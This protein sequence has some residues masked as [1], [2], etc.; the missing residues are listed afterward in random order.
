MPFG[1]RPLR[2]VISEPSLRPV[3]GQDAG[4]VP[5]NLAV[6]G[7]RTA[8][9]NNL[10]YHASECFRFV[11]CNVD[12]CNG[13]L[14]SE[15]RFRKRSTSLM[16]VKR[17]AATKSG[18]R[19]RAV[20]GPA[21]DPSVCRLYRSVSVTDKRRLSVK[22]RLFIHSF[23]EQIGLFGLPLFKCLEW[24]LMPQRALWDALV[25][26]LEVGGQGLLQLRR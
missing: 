23:S 18:Q 17:L 13:L 24:G 6:S 12:I 21:R 14:E 26:G 8:I 16:P 19:L 25:V 1:P 22:T 3:R 15:Q 4:L 20:S 10:S 9:G 7:C 5:A 2:T 11:S